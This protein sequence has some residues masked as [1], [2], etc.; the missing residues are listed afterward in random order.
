MSKKDMLEAR[1]GE[2]VSELETLVSL[3]ESEK[4]TAT[5]EEN[6]RQKSLLEDHASVT[7]KIAAAVDAENTRAQVALVLPA[8]VSAPA[9]A[10]PRSE[11][12]RRNGEH[13]YFRDLADAQLKGSSEARDRLVANDRHRSARLLAER[14]TRAGTTAA[15]ADGEFAPPLWEVDQFV[16]FLRPAR[17]FADLFTHSILQPG[18]SSINL[19]KISTGALTGAQSSQNSAVSNR[20][21]ATTSVSTG[22]STIAGQVVVSQQLLDQ[23]AINIDAVIL[24]DL[25]ADYAMQLDLA[26]ITAVSGVSGLNA[27][28]YTA[29]SPTSA[30]ILAAA[31]QGIDA[32]HQGVYRP[33]TA[34]VMRPDR[35]GRLLAAVDGQNRPLVLPVA[36]YGAYNVA[37]IGNGQT[38]Q[39]LAGTLRGVPV[40]LDASIPVNLGAGTNQDEIFVLRPQEI[41]L[42]ES[43]P[44][45]EVF[46]QTYANNLSIL[47]RFY[48]YYGIIPNRL[49]KAISVISG[50][51]MIPQSYGV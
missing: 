29:A 25:A 41:N 3:L 34:I 50:T 16:A 27:I 31:Q 39:G 17:P 24:A 45:A 4:R 21:F 47:C 43:A 1:K 15:G 13:S 40:Y 7:K 12:Y 35:W 38:P 23:S 42:Y 22:I 49:P 26:A 2:I 30:G 18:I 19:P 8:A 44:K 32:V 48:A 28:T 5:K 51:G 11:P 14:E 33:A 46:Q 37:G 6:E 9:L 36:D 20:D 10:E